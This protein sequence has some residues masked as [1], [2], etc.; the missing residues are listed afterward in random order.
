MKSLRKLFAVTVVIALVLGTMAV[1]GS[2]A[3]LTDVAGTAYADAANRLAALGVL[4]GYPD[5][6]FKGGNTI[7]RAEF[8]AVAVRALGLKSAAEIAA[9]ATNFSDVPATHWASGYINVASDQGLIKGYPDGTFK[10][11]ANVTYAESLAILVR[12]AGYEPVITG[13]W[14]TN[15]IVKAASLGLTKDVSFSAN[16]PATRGDVARFTD[17]TLTVALLEQTVFGQNPQW[18]PNPNKTLLSD[19]L[20]ASSVEGTLTASPE[21]FGNASDK[22]TV[23][24]GV[25]TTADDYTILSAA[26]YTGLLG[27]KVKA[28]KNSDGKVFFIEDKTDA[29]NVKTAKWDSTD[30]RFEIDDKAIELAATDGS[31]K[32]VVN[33]Q[34]SNVTGLADITS[35]KDNGEIQVI[36]NSDGKVTW[37][38]G[39]NSTVKVVDSVSTAFSSVTFRNIGLSGGG[40]L[41]LKDKT[42]TFSG[43]ASKLDELKKNDVLEYVE[44]TIGS[45]TYVDIIVTRNAKSGELS[46]LDINGSKATVGGTQYSEA[47]GF[48][49]D[50]SLVGKQVTVLLNKHGKIVAAES[51]A[52]DAAKVIAAIKGDPTSETYQA[53]NHLYVKV[54]KADNTSATLELA[55]DATIDSDNDGDTDLTVDIGTTTVADLT[56][57]N[58]QDR[59]IIEY[60]LDSNGKINKITV[61]VD[62]DTPGSVEATNKDNSLIGDSAST[63]N[64]VVNRSTAVFDVQTANDPKVVSTSRLL[65][66]NDNSVTVVTVKTSSTS[67]VAKVVAIK[68]TFDAPSA[69]TFGLVMGRYMTSGPKYYLSVLASGATTDYEV[70]QATHDAQPA[71]SV[72]KFSPSDFKG[73]V[74][75][76]NEL[77][78]SSSVYEWRVQ[79][80]DSTNK[81]V[82]VDEYEKTTGNENPT[83]KRTALL[84]T[85]KSLVFNLNGSN[86]AT[87]ARFEDLAVGQTVRVYWASGSVSGSK[88]DVITIK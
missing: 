7:T 67:N 56:N 39:R 17:K 9:G 42:V 20:G 88:V 21:L 8:A 2:A 44:A 11:D 23:D 63:G 52:A 79:A 85:S 77:T 18:A 71:D 65:S 37:V 68:G 54:L 70:T 19:R 25:G 57:N 72:V 27:H 61:L 51:T 82:Y 13:S 73:S 33:R 58:V 76:A 6:S 28:W 87:E 81:I 22:I 34:K 64:L 41:S 50:T 69:D 55:D 47:S 5:G 3:G 15:Y 30:A 14:P 43:A 16:N 26:A 38:T 59:S 46:R 86:P 40:S 78:V 80:I 74:T 31:V 36:V 29:G 60:T 83:D 62:I 49:T 12:A 4:T 1:G 66:D 24:D 45:K 48:D 35:T 75:A 10:P 53:T 32:Q 84:F